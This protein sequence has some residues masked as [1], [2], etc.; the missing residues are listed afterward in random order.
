MTEVFLLT[1]G[2]SDNNGKNILT[3]WGISNEIG[4]VE[5]RITNSNPLFFVLKDAEIT[6]LNKPYRRKSIQLKNFRSEPVDALYFNTQ[7]ELLIAAEYLRKLNIA[8]FESDVDPARRY[9]ME[10]FIYAQASLTG[11]AIREGKSTLF[12]NPVIKP[13]IVEPEFRVVSLDIETGRDNSVYSIACNLWGNIPE[14]KVVFI[15]GKG[16]A[17]DRLNYEL[18]FADTEEDLLKLFIDWFRQNDPDIIIGWHVIGFD[19]MFLEQRCKD[20]N[21]TFDISRKG[22]IILRNKARGGYYASIPGRIVLDGPISLRT[23]FYSFED[24]TL[25]TVSQELL[26]TG[27]TISS[28]KGKVEEIN[29]LFEEDKNKLAEYNLNDTILV[30]EIFKKTGIIKQNIK[31]AQL[32]GLMMDRLGM[33]TAAFDHFYLPKL[34]REGFVAP[35]VKDIEPA[36]QA[37]GGYVIEPI[38]GIYENVAVLDF[39][40]LYPSIMVT[41]KI[42]PLSRLYNSIEPISTPLGYKFSSVKHYLPELISSLMD[43]RNKAKVNNDRYLSQA[44]KILMNSF[45]G[46]M[47]SYGCRFYHPDLPN[48]ITSTGQWLLLGSKDYLEQKGYKVLYGD[49]DSLFVKIKEEETDDPDYSGNEIVKDLNLYWKGKLKADF[50]VD[51]YL[52]IEYEKF[53]K[54]FVLTQSRGSESGAKKRYAG[55]IADDGEGKIEFVGME[56]VRSDWTKLAKDFQ[57]ELYNR[58]LNDKEIKSWINDLV[59]SLKKGNYDSKLV[60][61]K[62]LR[63]DLDDYIKNVPPQVKAARMLDDKSSSV[64]YV[65]TK[66]GPVPIGLNPTDIDYNHYIEKQLKPIADS[67]LYL[68]GTSFDTIVSSEQLNF[69]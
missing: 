18:L 51:S 58:I 23:A 35:D 62:R 17:A 57:L 31:R 38:P 1:E 53:Y 50:N 13:C 5:I 28:D 66:K 15:R 40:S 29:R 45:Y 46:V 22:N 59:I 34:H 19:L 33:M 10:R 68:L 9:L 49:T 43:Q 67:I 7:R 25:E 61:R 2:W 26:G 30:S 36:G 6:S 56:S 16:K 37:A 4:T 14:T 48:A 47:G 69:F 65:I 21:I 12:I 42:D 3:Y 63:K 27:K 52:E 64:K 54:K 44:I 39:K 8:V 60:Y 41:F 32:S 24:F 55:L 20:L 11:E